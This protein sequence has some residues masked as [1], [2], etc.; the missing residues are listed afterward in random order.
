[1]A[2]MNDKA[3]EELTVDNGKRPFMEALEGVT[4]GIKEP[5]HTSLRSI[6]CTYVTYTI[7]G[8]Y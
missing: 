5:D 2:Q 3:L 4:D 7:S 8:N 6:E 1:M